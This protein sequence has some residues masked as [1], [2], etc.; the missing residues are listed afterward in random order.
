LKRNAKVDVASR[1]KEKFDL[2]L[3][4][5]EL[6][7]PH[8]SA[9]LRYLRLDLSDARIENT[10][11]Q[12]K[13]PANTHVQGWRIYYLPGISIRVPKEQFITVFVNCLNPGAWFDPQHDRVLN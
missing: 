4:H 9:S 11:I 6:T 2:L 3:G 13:A 5:L 1:L 7:E 12:T 8:I 10:N